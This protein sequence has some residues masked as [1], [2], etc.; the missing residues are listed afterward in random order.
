MR[1]WT[2]AKAAMKREAQTFD[3]EKQAAIAGGNVWTISPRAAA[4]SGSSRSFA[5]TPTESL[6]YHDSSQALLRDGPWAVSELAAEIK[7]NADFNIVV[8][9]APGVVLAAFPYVESALAAFCCR[10]QGEKFT[11]GEDVVLRLLASASTASGSTS[12][13]MSCR[14]TST[15]HPAQARLCFADAHRSDETRQF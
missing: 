6:A 7:M 11:L 2:Q 3:D 1:F 10:R 4:S 13:P 12:R 5:C 15:S 9:T 14:S 8:R